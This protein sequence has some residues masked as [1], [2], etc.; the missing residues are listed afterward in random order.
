MLA[1]IATRELWLIWHE[2]H[3]TLPETP[4]VQWTDELGEEKVKVDVEMMVT[5]FREILSNAAAFSQGGPV[6]ITM[7]CEG[8]TV[9]LEVREPK[10]TPLDPAGWVQPFSRIRQGHY[11]LGFW[12]AR[13][14]AQTQGGTLEQCYVPE[15][16]QLI[17]ETFRARGVRVTP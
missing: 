13:R 14:L 1:P 7:R 16:R 10:T 6:A 8:E 9:T 4:E 5:I 11:G 3:A 12:S 2:Q 15:E 17:S